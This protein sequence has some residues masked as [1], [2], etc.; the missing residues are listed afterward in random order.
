MGRQNMD[1]HKDE[2]MSSTF[3][4]EIPT[5]KDLEDPEPRGAGVSSSCDENCTA[6]NIPEVKAPVEEEERP[7]ADLELGPPIQKPPKF[8]FRNMNVKAVQTKKI[9][10]RKLQQPPLQNK[11]VKS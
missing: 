3:L 7:F 1:Q 4:K 9:R 10:F 6:R 5:R 11:A 2:P 8:L